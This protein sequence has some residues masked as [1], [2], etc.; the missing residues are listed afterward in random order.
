MAEEN[1]IRKREKI[2]G[3]KIHLRLN[4]QWSTRDDFTSLIF[5]SA[6]KLGAAL[7]NDNFQYQD[8]FCFKGEEMVK[9]SILI[10]N[11]YKIH[12]QW[13]ADSLQTDEGVHSKF[14]GLEIFGMH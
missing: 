2:N 1:E 13:Q 9:I 4:T 3:V 6:W 5:A 11:H 14:L 7:K 12:L 8:I 10:H